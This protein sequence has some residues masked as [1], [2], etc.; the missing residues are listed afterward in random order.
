MVLKKKSRVEVRKKKF[1]LWKKLWDCLDKY[2]KVIAVRCNHITARIFHDIRQA[3]R[4]LNAVV[5]MGKN[6]LL[7]AGITRKMAEPKVGDEDYEIRKQ[8]YKPMPELESLVGVCEGYLGLIFCNDNLS[9]IKTL[10]KNYQCSKGAK[11]GAIS[12]SD[13]TLPPGP[14]GMDPKQTS[15]FQALSIQTKIVRAQI[16]I[17]NPFKIL[18]K[19]QKI[20]A[21][22]CSLLDR[23]GIRPFV[24]EVDAVNVYDNGRIYDP[25]IL[26]IK[27]EDIFAKMR[28]GASHLAAASMQVG[29]PTT[30]SVKQSIMRGFKYLVASSVM[31][32][33]DFKA[34]KE[35][36][37]AALHPTAAAPV[38]AVT[39]QEKKPE[40]K[41][42]VEEKVEE[43]V[44]GLGDIFGNNE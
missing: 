26:D 33:Y 23:L 2:K 1:E 8:T 15:F 40:T 4:P 43:P 3:L 13:V 37:E 14:T 6:T 44:A 12:P 32:T 7:K 27:K 5:V 36:K 35:L 28:K 38:A 42:P 25:K 18:T 41:A 16:E 34:A 31:T 20:T 30:V 29:Y 19:G 22:E 11:V 21:S 9:E 24:Y 10:L 39:V 17:I